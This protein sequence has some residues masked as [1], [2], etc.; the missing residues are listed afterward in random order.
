[1]FEPLISIGQGKLLT[2]PNQGTLCL[3]K[4]LPWQV[5]EIH[6]SKIFFYCNIVLSFYRYSYC[7][8]MSRLNK[9]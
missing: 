1:M 5:I 2:T 4:S 3:V 9:A 8:K 7:A 6:G